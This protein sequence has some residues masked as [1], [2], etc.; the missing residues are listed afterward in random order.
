MSERFIEREPENHQ[1]HFNDL[2]RALY[3]DVQRP[4]LELD[5]Y[6]EQE[7]LLYAER[8]LISIGVANIYANI[9]GV[10]TPRQHM[11]AQL[12][13][14]GED[15]RRLMPMVA[16][17]VASEAAF[18]PGSTLNTGQ[19][20]HVLWML[21]F[22]QVSAHARRNEGDLGYFM[23]GFRQRME[24]MQL[25]MRAHKNI[26]SENLEESKALFRQFNLDHHEDMRTFGLEQHRES[27]LRRGLGSV[28]K[29]LGTI[30]PY[31]NQ[32]FNS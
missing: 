5:E 15:R 1:G 26:F 20:A 4:K 9:D 31:S 18:H 27:K 17:V 14:M 23:A 25:R 3:L 12:G 6:N 2:L 7:I 13:V 24:T 21:R 8:F 32:K 11:E 10:E 16:S 30:S 29:M 28:I 22:P 19:K